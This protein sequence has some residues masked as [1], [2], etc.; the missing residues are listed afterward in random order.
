MVERTF[1][2]GKVVKRTLPVLEAAAAPGAPV[3]RLL[4]PQGELAQ[5]FDGDPPIR[6]IA[7]VELRV[8][9]VRGN[10]YHQVKEEWFYTVH[11]ELILL[12]E[13]IASAARASVLLQAGDLAVIHTGIAHAWQPVSPGQAIEFSPARFDPADIHQYRLV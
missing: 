6:Y 13:D 5:F 7:A 8:G 1:L 9:R 2:S 11:G 10:H 12:V 4:L 3:K